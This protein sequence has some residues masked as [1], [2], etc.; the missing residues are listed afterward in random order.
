MADSKAAVRQFLAGHR[1]AEDRQKRLLQVRGAAPEQAIAECLSTLD[2]L[3]RLGVWP[4]P[5]DRVSEREATRVRK[6]WAKVKGAYS[7]A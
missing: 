6:L 4:G 1:A 5:R 3:E 7:A 2:A